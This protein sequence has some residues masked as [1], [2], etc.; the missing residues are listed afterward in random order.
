MGEREDERSDA[1]KDELDRFWDIDALLPVRRPA[2]KRADTETTEIVLEPIGDPTKSGEGTVVI[3]GEGSLKIPEGKRFI[4]PHTEA[5]QSR[6]PQPEEEYTPESALI[7]SVRIYRWKSA[8]RYYE[9]FVRDAEKFRSYQGKEAAPVPFFSYVPQYSQ[10]NRSQAQWYLWWRER[11][12][13]GEWLDTDYSYLLLYVYELINL[14]DR[15]E[16]KRVQRALLSVWEHYHGTYPQLNSYLPEWIC[17]HALIHHV[18]PPDCTPELRTEIM[19]HCAVKEFYVG[20]ETE[21]GYAGCLLMFCSN[22]DYRKSKFY[23][24][25]TR[26]LYDKTVLEVLKKVSDGMSESGK[27]FATS[28]MEDSTLTRDAYIGAL[29]SYRIKRKIGI[30]YCSF[31]R[32]HELR[33]LVTDIVKFTENQLRAYL[34]IRSRISIYALP[35]SIRSEI[36]CYFAETLPPRKRTP[37]PAER[38]PAEYE[39][40]YD[41]P[42]KPFSPEHAAEIERA[43]WDTTQKLVE[44]FAEEPESP[45]KTEEPE[46]RE[47]PEEPKPQPAKT[48]EEEPSENTFRCAAGAY[49]DFLRAVAKADPIGQRRAADALGMMPEAVADAVNEIAADFFGDIL[50][51]EGESGWCVIEDY[52][53]LLND[54]C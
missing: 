11:A 54:F 42:K 20:G 10:L 5:E 16:P 47:T 48:P 37:K 31:S 18:P 15:M 26:A 34:G 49:A 32:S 29:C 17:D 6:E 27:L 50:L 38:E 52:A 19:K 14:S 21:N 2:P 45:K 43:S 36:E 1:R 25:E 41:L 39:K 53:D 33:F 28:G 7:H 51:E 13:S 3:H 24:E 8:Y 12:E 4:P 22:Y 40:L 44:A 30:S 9:D 35:V 46:L 23:N